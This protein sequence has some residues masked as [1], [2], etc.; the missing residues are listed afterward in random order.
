[1]HTNL[2]LTAYHPAANGL[3]ERFHRHLKGALRAQPNPNRWVENLP[4]VLLGCRAAVKSDLKCSAADLV[5]GTVLRLQSPDRKENSSTAIPNPTLLDI[6]IRAM[7]RK[8]A[9]DPDDI[10]PTFFKALGPTAKTELLSI[11]NESFCSNKN[12]R[13]FDRI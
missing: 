8:G 1:M 11:F 7:R 13:L 9:A 6:A 10:P 4:L 3:L 2:P 12:Q 5:Y